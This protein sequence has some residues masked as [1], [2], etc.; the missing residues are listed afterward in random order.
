MRY[1]L[2]IAPV[3]IDDPRSCRR[4]F[5]VKWAFKCRFPQMPCLSFPDA[6]RF[7]RFRTDLFVLFFLAMV[8]FSVEGGNGGAA[9]F[10][11]P[12]HWGGA[13]PSGL[14]TGDRSLARFGKLM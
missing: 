8:V 13:G 11:T 14:A 9:G 10:G 2:T 3:V 1:F 7:I 6:V 4:C 5:A 12:W